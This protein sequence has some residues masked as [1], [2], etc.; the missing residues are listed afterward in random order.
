[1]FAVDLKELFTKEIYDEFLLFM[2]ERNYFWLGKEENYCQVM[3]IQEFLIF[4]Y[5]ENI[6]PEIME[7]CMNKY[8]QILGLVSENI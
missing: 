8:P 5:G 2:V 1:M 3:Y 4:K 6:S 7:N